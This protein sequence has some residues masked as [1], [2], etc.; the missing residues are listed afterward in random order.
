M[1]QLDPSLLQKQPFVALA[2]RR[3]IIKLPYMATEKIQSD[4]GIRH[5]RWAMQAIWVYLP[6]PSCASAR[7]A[8]NRP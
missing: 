8:S 3:P 1:G 7:Q 5:W 4:A 6:V 2:A